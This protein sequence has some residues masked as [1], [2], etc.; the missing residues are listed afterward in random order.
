MAHKGN[1]KRL[2]EDMAFRMVQAYGYSAGGEAAGKRYGRDGQRH[3]EER[4]GK[5]KKSG[6]YGSCDE[7]AEKIPRSDTLILFSADE[8]KGNMFCYQAEG[9]DGNISA[10]EGKG[11]AQKKSKGGVSV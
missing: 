7:I 4:S 3:G 10:Y 6:N 2:P 8:H 11:L 1:H 5:G 9:I